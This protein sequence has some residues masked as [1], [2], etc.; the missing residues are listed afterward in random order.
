MVG[1]WWCS[2]GGVGYRAPR[3]PR[4]DYG[5]PGT[6][7][8]T[9]NAASFNERHQTLLPAQN[10]LLYVHRS[11]TDPQ[12]SADSHKVPTSNVTWLGVYQTIVCLGTEDLENFQRE[13][14]L[15]FPLKAP[16][17]C[18]IGY[19]SETFLLVSCHNTIQTCCSLCTVN[20]KNANKDV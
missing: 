5:R 4:G 18:T 15:Q 1:S 20:A 16:Q 12:S 6:S 3:G 13:H 10:I 2:D 8:S 7:K 19:L 14:G 17:P 9:I 11:L